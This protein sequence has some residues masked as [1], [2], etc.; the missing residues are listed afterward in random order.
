VLQLAISPDGQ[1]VCSVGD[2]TL[3]FWK[4]FD[5]PEDDEDEVEALL[6]GR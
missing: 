3:R 5:K 1:T 4:I 6:S 2:E